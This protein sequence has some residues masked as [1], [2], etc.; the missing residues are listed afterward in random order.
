[1]TVMSCLRFYITGLTLMIRV[2]S[3]IAA[4]TVAARSFSALCLVEKGFQQHAELFKILKA[5]TFVQRDFDSSAM[6]PAYCSRL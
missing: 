4:L 3:T 6:S 1:M 5:I 2:V